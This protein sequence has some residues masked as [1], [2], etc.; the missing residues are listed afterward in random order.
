MKILFFL[1]L[2]LAALISSV[3]GDC[4]WTGCQPN[5]WAVVGCAQY[6][7][8]EKDRKPCSG[9]NIYYCCANSGGGGGGDQ[10]M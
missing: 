2:V 6:G 5:S 7:R 1:T 4:W 8:Q 9:G 10:G 3:V